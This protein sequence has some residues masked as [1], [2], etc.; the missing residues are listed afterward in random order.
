M[1]LNDAREHYYA[2][3]GKASDIVRQLGLAGIALV[4]IFK[5]D[6]AGKIVVPQ[7]LIPVSILIVAGLAADL[8]Q[9]VFGSLCWG[10]FGHIKDTPDCDPE[11]PLRA[12]AWIN[13]PAIIC[14]WIKIILISTAYVLLLRYLWS[15]LA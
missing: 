12:P 4:W 7:A 1:N 9:Y 3:T 13:A 2:H 14:F 6:V 10:I 5:T 11:A 15:Q 8:L